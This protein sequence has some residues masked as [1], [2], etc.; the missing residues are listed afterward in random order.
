MYIYTHTNMYITHTYSVILYAYI[1]G[2]NYRK[3]KNVELYNGDHP[4]T[5]TLPTPRFK[6]YK[7][8]HY[9]SIYPSCVP[10]LTPCRL[11]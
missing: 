9:C 1:F 7:L 6:S 4:L 3:F 2:V 8:I 10:P 5:S 11:F